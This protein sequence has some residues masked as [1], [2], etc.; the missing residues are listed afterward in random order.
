MAKKRK[1]IFQIKTT[2]QLKVVS[3]PVLI[4]IVQ[5]LRYGGPA[6]VNE[7]GKRI[8]RKPNSLHYHFR[9][10]VKVG[11]VHKTDTR[12]SGA[13]TEAIYDVVADE[14]YGLTIQ[15]DK[16]LQ[17]LT[18][19]GI[20]ALLRLAKRNVFRAIKTPEKLR[21]TGAERNIEIQRSAARLTNEQ[22]AEVNAHIDAL[23]KIFTSNIG[24]EEGQMCSLT[25]VLTPLEDE[26]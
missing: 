7:V 25:M 1:K 15:E 8:G 18:N 22:L 2:E 20:A 9:K 6:T 26:K 14:F 16:S 23:R 17:K 11:F 21:E 19:D 13:R 4:E 12:L 3:S 10:L 5:A 24:T